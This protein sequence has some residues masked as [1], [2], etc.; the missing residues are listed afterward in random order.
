MSETKDSFN[1]LA[2]SLITLYFTNS[3]TSLSRYALDSYNYFVNKELPEL[4]FNQNPITI[5]KEPLGPPADGQYVYK[6]EIFIGGSTDTPANLGI[7]F[8]YPIIVLDGGKTIRRMFPQE[9]RLRNLSYS[10]TVLVDIRIKIT[11]TTILAGTGVGAVAPTYTHTEILNIERKSFELFKLPIMLRSSLCVTNT[12]EGPRLS[13]L[14]E[15]QFDQ[16]GYFIVDGAEKVLI[17]S[18]DQAFNSIYAG[19]KPQADQKIAAWATCSSL[20][21]KNKQIRRT[22]LFLERESGAIRVSLPFVRGTVPLFIVFR[23]LGVQTDKD[24]VSMIIPNMNSDEMKVLEPWLTA[25]IHDAY[26]ITDSFLAIQFLR[27]LTKGFL[28]ETVLDIL[29][30]NVFTHVPKTFQAKALFLGEMTRQLLRVGADLDPNTDRDDIRNKRYLTAGTLVRELFTSCWKQWVKQMT[31][32][33]DGEYNYN[34]S[35]YEGMN[36]VNIFSEGNFPKMLNGETLNG[37]ILRGFRGKWG[38]DANNERKGVI[39]PLA[40]ISYMDAMSQVRRVSLDFTLK[41]PGPRRLHPSQ[42]GFFCISEVPSGF[43]IG[44]TKNASIFTIFSLAESSDSMLSFLYKKCGV[45][46]VDKGNAFKREHWCR[47]QLNGGTVGFIKD[48]ELAVTVLKLCK[49]TGC[50]GPTTSISFNRPSRTVKIFMD[51]GRPCRPLWILKGVEEKE[52]GNDGSR[53]SPLAKRM[54]ELGWKGLLKGILAETR[55]RDFYDT[56]FVDPFPEEMVLDRY[57][58]RLQP[59]SSALEYIDPYE[60]NEAYISWSGANDLEALHTHCE[61]HPSTMFGFVGSMIPFANH[62]QSPRNQLSCSQSKQ[63]IGFYSSQFMNRFDTYGTQMC[64]GEAP[65]AR[66]LYYDLI[67]DGNMPYGVNCIVALAS[68]DGY[69]MDDGILFNSSSIERGLFRHLSFKT[70]DGVEEKDPISGSSTKIGNPNRIT[71]WTSLKPG[72]DYS[73]LDEEGIIKEGSFV[74]SST[75]LIGR[76][77]V[78]PETGQIKDA[79]ITPTVFTQGRVEKVVIL[80]QQNGQRLVHIRVFEMRVPELGDKFSSRH[81]QKGTIGML[82]PSYDLPRCR[83]GIVPDIV[84]NPHCIPSRMTVAQIMEMITSKV[85]AQCGAKM[86][87]TSFTNDER[88][89]DIMGAALEA[90]GFDKNGEEIMYSPFTGK[91][92]TSTIFSCPLYFMRLR[93]LTQ[94]KIN[95][96]GAGRKEQRTHQPT[97]GRGN[98]GG[99]VLVKWNVMF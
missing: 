81:G 99:Y 48:P 59:Y 5:L 82:R 94:D 97:G 21:P 98:E 45:I 26:P 31:L 65:I 18:E 32:T 78:F 16:G 57:V 75:V 41:S 61:I 77:T 66:T 90:E 72:V 80:H 35:I 70:Y 27:T 34:R 40:R 63:G 62:N 11:M 83:N 56:G 54:D 55:D 36:F 37:A 96:R 50:T 49:Q 71:N 17:T 53:M 52:G 89:H 1:D 93:H 91:Q 28:N 4:L 85:G 42:C 9:A 74:D 14:G 22:A 10:A 38:T 58:A 84:V 20:N 95:A 23:A 44:I 43:S 24:I 67:A 60:Q 12:F 13:T 29:Y 51:E 87:A 69:N 6:T 7:Q 15:C 3:T 39:Q 86:N 19:K 64:Y 76:Y 47:V 25:C 88:H 46:A 68:F 2:S 92:Y 79:S 33:I 73:M 8:G 30:N